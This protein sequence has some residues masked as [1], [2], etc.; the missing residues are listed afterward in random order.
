MRDARLGQRLEYGA[1]RFLG[2]VVTWLPG[3]MAYALGAAIGWLAG[4]VLRI[5]RS[6]VRRNLARA[7]PERSVEWRRRV[8]RACYRH[9]GV[10]AVAILRMAR[11]EPDELIRRTDIPELGVLERALERGR[12][13]LILTGHLGN[14]EMA[15]ASLAARG[16]PVYAVARRQG[17]PLFDRYLNR[18]RSRMGL[19]VIEE[20][21]AVK[22]VVDELRAGNVVALV[23]D[24]NVR[25]G[26]AFVD[27]FGHPA[28][29]VRGPALFA[30]RSGAPVLVGAMLRREG[31]PGWYRGVVEALDVERT[32]SRDA[33]VERLLGEFSRVLEKIVRGAPEQY[34][35]QH[36]RWKTRPPGESGEAPAR[37]RLPSESV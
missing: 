7:F 36:K 28:S 31:R 14:W 32:G 16:M 13:A 15:G 29:T 18:T 19:R 30:L 4:S 8:G 2:F 5:R 25:K 10:E 12:G 33:D 24:Q 35:W 3:P 11:T 37:N 17:N 6:V 34:F 23:A 26:G 21:H 20:G 1:L 27:F 22:R 9:L